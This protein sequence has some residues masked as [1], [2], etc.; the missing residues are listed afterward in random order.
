MLELSH[1][2]LIEGVDLRNAPRGL[3]QVKENH[4]IENIA[5]DKLSWGD[6]T[7]A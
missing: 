2:S 5:Y 3:R 1:H 4:L 6:T 7:S